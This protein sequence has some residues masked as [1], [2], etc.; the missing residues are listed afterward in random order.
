MYPDIPFHSQ[1]AES[2]CY[3]AGCNTLKLDL[4][5]RILRDFNR[6]N[7][8]HRDQPM[9][10]KSTVHNFFLRRRR[11]CFSSLSSSREDLFRS[12]CQS[13]S[14]KTF[15]CLPFWRGGHLV[16]HTAAFCH[17]LALRL[18]A[19]LLSQKRVIYTSNSLPAIQ[20]PF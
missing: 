11:R 7:D 17:P 16:W 15:S 5:S 9:S 12:F 4:N 8:I 2:G 6:S 3:C 18:G 20:G 10:R 19:K 13:G 14:V 1:A